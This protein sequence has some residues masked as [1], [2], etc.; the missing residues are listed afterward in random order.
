MAPPS[1]YWIAQKELLALH[2][3]LFGRQNAPK[4]EES[5]VPPPPRLLD[6]R[7]LIARARSAT[8]GVKFGRLWCGQWKGDYSSQSEADLAL[9]CLLAFWT[10]ND[11]V[12]I[13]S[14][15]RQSGL[16]R[17]KWDREDYRQ[18]TIDAALVQTTESYKPSRRAKSKSRQLVKHEGNPS[19]ADDAIPDLLCFAHTDTGNAERLV[20]LFGSE[21]RF[22]IEMR[23]W[24]V[25]DGRRWVINDSR[26]VKQLFKKTIREMYKQ[27]A[28]IG[29]D[30]K[31][32]VSREARPPVRGSPK[33]PSRTGMC[34]A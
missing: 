22:C 7:K 21:I 25:W 17:E 6:D 29:N 20:Q 5:S 26:N 19:G 9:C 3:R 18:R 27:A 31:T 4:K 10:Q 33:D 14:L 34:G 11:A 23:K 30:D 12:Q 1:K 24:L 13:D 32:Q 16:M 15:F 28:D 8:N 2:Q